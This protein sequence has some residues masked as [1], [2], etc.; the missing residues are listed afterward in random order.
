METASEKS[1]SKKM[2]IIII[3]IYFLHVVPTEQRLNF[4]LNYKT[5]SRD[6]GRIKSTVSINPELR[7][8]VSLLTC[9]LNGFLHLQEIRVQNSVQCC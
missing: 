9:F 3:S 2:L 1:V 8:D 5:Q 4:K 7:E 6:F